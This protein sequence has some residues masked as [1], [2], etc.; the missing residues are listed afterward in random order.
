MKF[1]LELS[2]IMRLML[3]R[4]IRCPL[5]NMKI[6][7]SFPQDVLWRVD[8]KGLTSGLELFNGST[9]KHLNKTFRLL[10]ASEFRFVFEDADRAYIDRFAPMHR[11]LMKERGDNYVVDFDKF[12]VGTHQHEIKALSLYQGGT[13]LGGMIYSVMSRSLCLFYRVLPHDIGL[14]LPAPLARIADVMLIDKAIA[15]KKG[16]YSLGKDRN[17]FGITSAIGLAGYKLMGKAKPYIY[18]RGSMTTEF[19]WNEKQDV[20][21]FC[22]EQKSFSNKAKLLLVEANNK[23]KYKFLEQASLDLDIISASS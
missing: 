22:G 12:F 14:N 11:A 21:V 23:G 5:I 7:G 4:Q 1:G 20:L 13:Y 18:S 19:E 8:I 16:V 17:F 2:L 9:L 15:L 6:T 10:N 3:L